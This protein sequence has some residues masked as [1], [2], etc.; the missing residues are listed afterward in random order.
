MLYTWK[1]NG[2]AGGEKY[3]FYECLYTLWL[4]MDHLVTLAPKKVVPPSKQLPQQ[5]P[6]SAHPFYDPHHFHQLCL[7]PP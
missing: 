1:G 3:L 7:T 2:S 4:H 5:H 6:N